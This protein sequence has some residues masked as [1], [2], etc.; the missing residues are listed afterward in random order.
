[1]L[2]LTM[3]CVYFCNQIRKGKVGHLRS[4]DDRDKKPT[5]CAGGKD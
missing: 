3:S 4:S 2:L 1:V 5:Q